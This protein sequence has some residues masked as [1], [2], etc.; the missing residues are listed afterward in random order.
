MNARIFGFFFSQALRRDNRDVDCSSSPRAEFGKI[1]PAQQS[2]TPEE[3]LER[4]GGNYKSLRYQEDFRFLKN[5]IRK[6]DFW[7]PIKYIPFG[8]KEDGYLSIGG[9]MRQRYMLQGDLHLGSNVRIFT[10]FLSTLEDWRM[11]ESTLPT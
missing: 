9:E 2:G 6:T 4:I 7:E 10:Q 5:L 8:E 1:N 3:K 11:G